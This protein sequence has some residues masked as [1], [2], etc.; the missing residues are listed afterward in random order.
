MSTV[1]L[2]NT[3]VNL[4]RSLLWQHNQATNLTALLQ[5]KQ[6]WYDDNH[7]DFWD[8]WID[9][10]F[11]IVTASS[12]GLAVWSVIL[13]LPL[14]GD[15]EISPTNYPAFGFDTGEGFPATSP[16]QNFFGSASGTNGGNFATDATGAFGISTER[17]RILLRLRYIQLVTRA[18]IPEINRSLA[19]IFGPNEIYALDNLDMTMTY[20]LLGPQPRGM[21]SL[22][23]LFD[24]LPRP[25]GVEV[26]YTDAEISSFG[27]GEFNLNFNNGSF[28]AQQ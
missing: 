15:T 8:N 27:F 14:F 4:L 22:F 28:L 5:S 13:D 17:K 16:I 11:N 26:I 24:I 21:L 12:F 19:D 10:V 20:V 2:F 6:D 23:Q 7:S 25:A 18:A 3:S 9:D 1:Q